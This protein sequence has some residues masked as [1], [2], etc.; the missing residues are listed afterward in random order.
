MAALG[1]LLLDLRD[2]DLRVPTLG[3]AYLNRARLEGTNL[4]YVV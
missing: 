1:G 3:K 2:V 4:S